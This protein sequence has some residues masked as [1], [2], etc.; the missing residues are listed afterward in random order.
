MK[1]GVSSSFESTCEI[2]NRKTKG[3][4]L[5]RH[6]L[7][8]PES[9]GQGSSLWDLRSSR[10]GDSSSTKNVIILHLQYRLS[11]FLPRAR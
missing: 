7:D 10:S 1:L 3:C 9:P 8:S 11:S 2:K 6:H 5:A 4:R